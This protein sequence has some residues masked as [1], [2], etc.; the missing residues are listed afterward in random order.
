MQQLSEKMSVLLVDDEEGI[1]KV[2]GITLSDMGFRVHTADSGER[3]L[4]LFREVSP[5]LVLTDI[6]MPGMDGLALLRTIK[7]ENP[8]T[9][10][11][12][13][14]G[15]GDIDQAIESLKYEASDFITK[16]VSDD[17][18]AVALK[19]SLERIAMKDQLK[20]RRCCNVRVNIAALCNCANF[21]KS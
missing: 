16:P 13:I 20:K 8:D 1:R 19:R 12:M 21:R 18:L 11:I 15:H 10:V 5:G 4:S 7:K 17:A 3:A 9:E 2:L 6:K 14:S